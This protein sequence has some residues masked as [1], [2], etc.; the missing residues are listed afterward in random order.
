METPII[1]VS[2]VP[3]ETTPLVNHAL[4]LSI[5]S[6]TPSSTT[7]STSTAK[8]SSDHE[9]PEEL[10]EDKE[11]DVAAMKEPNRGWTPDTTELALTWQTRCR[12]MMRQKY[13]GSQKLGKQC[14]AA[15]WIGYVLSGI[16]A[17]VAAFQTGNLS[18]GGSSDDLNYAMGLIQGVSALLLMVVTTYQG[19]LQASY[20]T[21]VMYFNRFC[22]L[23][24][25][26]EEVTSLPIEVR[27]L[28]TSFLRE[29]SLKFYKYQSSSEMVEE[30]VQEYNRKQKLTEPELTLDQP[31]EPITF[32]NVLP[33]TSSANSDN[34][35]S[36]GSKKDIG[37][38]DEAERGL[39][40]K[41][42]GK[43]EVEEPSVRQRIFGRRVVKAKPTWAT[44][45]PQEGTLR[46]GENLQ[47]GKLPDRCMS[48]TTSLQIVIEQEEA[49]TKM[50]LPL[51]NALMSGIQQALDE[52]SSKQHSTSSS[53]QP[54]V[55][56]SR[57]TSTHLNPNQP[58]RRNVTRVQQPVKVTLNNHE[59]QGTLESI[60]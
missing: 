37:T 35:M 17:T 31:S 32:S 20:T 15:T 5:P 6:F 14:T 58:V 45:R 9:D 23:A 56:S 22:K 34:A 41:G 52:P 10:E 48:L 4:T 18:A 44:A 36:L 12:L 46:H 2:P 38:A 54:S 51:A 55:P 33:E 26:F 8:P 30:A 49:K 7:P 24:R 53:R 47:V 3:T 1:T 59:V 27:P 16:M 57:Q 13:L 42:E 40:L 39:M 21:E 29:S 60:V 28:A 43:Q 50:A 11:E 19:T 25:R